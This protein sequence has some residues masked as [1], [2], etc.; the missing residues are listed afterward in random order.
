MQV[1]IETKPKVYETKTLKITF[2]TEEEYRMFVVMLSFDISVP[3]VVYT[4]SKFNQIK[5]SE[6]MMKIRK[7][8]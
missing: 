7:V 5:L 4:E 8:L 6:Q 1:E 2:E 3:E